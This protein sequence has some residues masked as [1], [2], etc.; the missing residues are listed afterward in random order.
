MSY[1][2]EQ[3]V[4][5]IKFDSDPGVKDDRQTWATSVIEYGDKVLTPAEWEMIERR[6]LGDQL[7]AAY[8]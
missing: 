7:T 3:Y 5:A 2:T 1:S 4:Q 6:A 8:N